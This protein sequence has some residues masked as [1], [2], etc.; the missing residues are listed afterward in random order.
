MAPQ[1]PFKWKRSEK[2]IKRKKRNAFLSVLPYMVGGAALIYAS[3][4]LFHSSVKENGWQDCSIFV[5][6]SKLPHGGWG[7]FAARSFQKNEIVEVSPLHFPLPPKMPALKN[8]ALDDYFYTSD[9]YDDH[10]KIQNAAFPTLGYIMT[11][12]HHP[13]PNVSFDWAGRPPHP[14][15]PNQKSFFVMLKAKRRIEA[16]DEMFSNYGGSEGG[17]AWFIK[18][19]LSLSVR[20]PEE[21][22]LQAGEE[23]NT[24]MAHY[25]PKLYSGPG[26]PS[27]RKVQRS[28]RLKTTDGNLAPFYD[29]SRLAPVDAGYENIIARTTLSEGDVIEHAPTVVIPWALTKGT[30]L[31]PLV[32]GWDDLN[33]S[34]Q[35]SLRQLREEGYVTMQ[36]Q[37]Q[38]TRRED[39]TWKREERWQGFEN[40]AL[41]P[42]G[43]VGMIQRVGSSPESNCRLEIRSS[44]NLDQQDTAG[45]R[46]NA[47]LVLVLVATTSMQPG[48]VLRLNLPNVQQKEALLDALRSMGQPIILDRSMNDKVEL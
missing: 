24:A 44:V 10:G 38:D 14:D 6:P 15:D 48:D 29:L 21:S 9:Y 27:W 22:K 5:A 19:G 18:R 42:L 4:I 17:Q 43:S 41:F 37:G 20:P 34:L 7:V 39:Q 13:N 2:S 36:Y 23:L 26:H 12:N 28:N 46:G 33:D 47:G 40:V 16:G 3:S 8:S 45:V 1:K 11:N 32:F 30:E 31:E 25:C 35:A